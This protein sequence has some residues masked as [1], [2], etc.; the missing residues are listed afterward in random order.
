M[1]LNHIIVLLYLLRFLFLIASWSIVSFSCAAKHERC[2][3][4]VAS[5]SAA[6]WVVKWA[7][8]IFDSMSFLFWSLWTSLLSNLLLLVRERMSTTCLR[9]L[10]CCLGISQECIFIQH[11]A[12]SIMLCHIC[13]SRSILQLF[14]E[15]FALVLWVLSSHFI[16][17]KKY[18]Q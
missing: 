14:L 17:C 18:I 4:I 3:T 12:S 11:R 13:Q 16:N 6:L 8:P 2:F 9:C 5:S 10:S 1:S 15:L 7:V